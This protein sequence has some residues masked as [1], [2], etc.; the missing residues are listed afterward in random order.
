[1]NPL[2]NETA[3]R[4]RALDLREAG[5][6][7][8]ELAVEIAEKQLTDAEAVAARHIQQQ[9]QANE[10]DRELLNQQARQVSQE[11]KDREEALILVA[12]EQQKRDQHLQKEKELVKA[13]LEEDCKR[14]RQSAEAAAIEAV[15]RERN[16]AEL[17]IDEERKRTEES[18][19]RA[20][21]GTRDSSKGG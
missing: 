13:E 18:I 5:L 12:A 2:Q 3:Q 11:V 4:Q 14:L 20:Q 1:M 6:R 8:K 7:T 16:R 19:A 15:Q 10:L 21:G 9:A 17:S